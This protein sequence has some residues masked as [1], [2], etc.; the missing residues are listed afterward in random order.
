MKSIIYFIDEIYEDLELWYPKIRLEEEGHKVVVAGP[1][2][3]QIYKGKHGYP[4]KAD[5]AINEVKGSSY[6]AIAIPGGYAPDKL[7]RIPK[8][9][10]LVREF[11]AQKKVVA[12]IC[13]AG[14]VPISAKVLKGRKA[15]GASA[16]KDD[17]ENAGA[18]WKDEAVVVDK[19]LISSRTPADLPHFAKAII[20][21]LG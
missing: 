7:R 10:E 13:H 18:T 8:V 19:N 9:L 1:I 14:W 12:F 3:G 21:A 17:L 11:D 5:V 6:D 4:C 16:I 2:S 20:A 15:T